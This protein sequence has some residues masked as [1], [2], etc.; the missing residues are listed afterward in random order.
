MLRWTVDDEFSRPSVT[1]LLSAV[2]FSR[3]RR[4]THDTAWW[5]NARTS[6]PNV[7]RITRAA[8]I[9]REHI[10]AD[11]ILQNRLD[12]AAAQRRR[13]HALVRQQRCLLDAILYRCAYGILK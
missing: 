10:I 1:R 4:A 8:P 11:S 5:R 6:R 13:V 7:L 3:L 12:L 2:W 9:N